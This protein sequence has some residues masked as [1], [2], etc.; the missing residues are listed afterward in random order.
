MNIYQTETKEGKG[1][2]NVG[3]EV[4]VPVYEGEAPE[5]QIAATEDTEENN[6]EESTQ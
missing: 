1:D 6:T 3:D 4:A 5:E 2:P